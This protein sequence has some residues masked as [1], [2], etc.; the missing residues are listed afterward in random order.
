[1][2]R[3]CHRS[4]RWRAGRL[5]TEPLVASRCIESTQLGSF[6][7]QQTA[8]GLVGTMMPD[9]PEEY[10]YKSNS[11]TLVSFSVSIWA[12]GIVLNVNRAP[13]RAFEMALGVVQTNKIEPSSVTR[14]DRTDAKAARRTRRRH[15]AT[16]PRF[17]HISSRC[18]GVRRHFMVFQ[19]GH[20]RP[21]LNTRNDGRWTRYTALHCSAAP[22][23]RVS[24]RA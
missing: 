16:Q 21:L 1:M 5:E 4:A 22:A 8:P 9:D 18:R 20:S 17:A 3:R 24:A 10:L 11:H 12:C 6:S 14:T 15:G 13:A 23:P 19:V 7:D 2:S